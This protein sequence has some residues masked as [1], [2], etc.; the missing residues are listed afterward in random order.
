MIRCHSGLV[1]RIKTELLKH[2]FSPY[3]IN[4]LHCLIHQ[5]NPCVKVL[6]FKHV[7][8]TFVTCFSSI[9]ARGSNHRQFLKVADDIDAD[10]VIILYFTEVL[11][12]S[13]GKMLTF[14]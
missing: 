13:R 6:R 2:N 3:N 5:E 1:A 8:S 14:L 9:K 4:A 10:H 12:L 11:W 7:M